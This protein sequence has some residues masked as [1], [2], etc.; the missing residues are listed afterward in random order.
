M[1]RLGLIDAA[2]RLYETL[3][4]LERLGHDRVLRGATALQDGLGHERRD[5]RTGRGAERTVLG[6]SFDCKEVD[7]SADRLLVGFL[8][9]FLRAAGPRRSGRRMA[10]IAVTKAKPNVRRAIKVTVARHE[11]RSIIG[12]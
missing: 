9:E 3:Q 8:V 11:K 5:G 12:S 2:V 7:R 6:L 10:T 4:V 1:S